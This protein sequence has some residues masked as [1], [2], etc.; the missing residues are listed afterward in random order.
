M[1]QPYTSGVL[2]LDCS[3]RGPSNG[4]TWEPRLDVSLAYKGFE[5]NRIRAL[6]DSGSVATIFDA[7]V[8]ERLGI[9]IRSGASERLQGFSKT[10]DTLIYFH[11]VQLLVAG[12][13]VRT[14][15]GFCFGLPVTAL[16]GR[17]GFFE[18]FR[19]TFDP[20]RMGMQIDRVL[21]E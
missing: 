12:A 3:W 19:V 11:D 6:V 8:G 14:K 9:P 4:L 1:F 17:H 5:S 2:P 21:R 18:H 16:L 13:S 20:A 7:S 15:V 10:D